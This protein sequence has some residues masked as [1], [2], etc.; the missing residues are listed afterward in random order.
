M[1]VGLLVSL[2]VA[3]PAQS[4]HVSVNGSIEASLSSLSPRGQSVLSAQVARLLRWR[5]DIVKNV[6][7]GDALSILYEAG[8]GTEELELVAMSYRGSQIS[9]SAY[10]F[11]GP[12][13]V[14]R[15]YDEN[16]KLVEP[17]IINSPV[18]R[19]VQ[20]TETVQRGRG[21][22]P[23]AGMDFKAPEGTPVRLPFAGTVTRVNWS[24]RVNGNCI[25][26]ELPSGRI[27]HFLH[28]ARVAPEVTPGATLQPGTHLGE[29][30]TTGHSNAPHLHYEILEPS[31]HPL[32]PMEVHGT[33]TMTLGPES[34]P[35]FQAARASFD[36]SLAPGVARSEPAPAPGPA[37]TPAR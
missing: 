4:L 29:V 3:A 21:K 15:Y 20:I 37:V 11:V 31:G 22:R 24:R 12:D 33:G 28:L 2:S 9:L 17:T 32:E 1:L 18:E 14:A 16:G 35:A 30:G 10:R 13:G 27:L 34:Q 5:G 6:Q 25:E 36:R 23:H 8:T 26:L 19:Y 7:R